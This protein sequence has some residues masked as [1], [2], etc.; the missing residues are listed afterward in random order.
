MTAKYAELSRAENDDADDSGSSLIQDESISNNTLDIE[1]GSL[2]ATTAPSMQ[3]QAPKVID[4]N[5]S[6]VIRTLYRVFLSLGHELRLAKMLACANIILS[7]ALLAEPILF[8]KIVNAIATINK[9]EK[10][11]IYDTLYPLLLS[12][13]GF[14]I[15]GTFVTIIV[16]LK[17]DQMAHRQRHVITKQFFH[18]ALQSTVLPRPDDDSGKM[19]KVMT[20]GRDAMFWNWLT[21]LRHELSALFFLIILLPMGFFINFAM[22]WTLIILC[23]IYGLS[24]FYVIKKAHNLQDSATTLYHKESTLCSDVLSNLSLIQAYD[25]INTEV[26]NL[27]K[28]SKDILKYQLPILNY[29]VFVSMIN[30][31]S[32]SIA[33]VIIVIQ[34]VILYLHDQ[35]TVGDIVTFIY[36]ANSVISK[37]RVILDGI[38]RISQDMPKFKSFFDVFD[39]EPAVIDLPN[40]RGLDIGNRTF[41][42][43][44]VTNY[45]YDVT[46]YLYNITDN[47]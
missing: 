10:Q 20:E 39:K 27:G 4:A 21:I 25:H 45:L 14:S 44:D 33:M 5:I 41:L 7:I 47:L 24:A 9:T 46:N 2:D 32:T 16:G 42:L 36:F 30:Q 31:C 35:V 17:A 38:N 29:W 6:V 26:E 23:T 40:G 34:G 12:W 1:N 28:L 3:A 18:R 15:L 19:N 37:L 43:Y 11:D 22:S 13:S 8:G